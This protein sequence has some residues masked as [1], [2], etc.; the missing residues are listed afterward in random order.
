MGTIESQ[1]GENLSQK[2]EV[3]QRAGYEGGF[4][5]SKICPSISRMPVEP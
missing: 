4:G 2:Y 5:T 1:S 3:G